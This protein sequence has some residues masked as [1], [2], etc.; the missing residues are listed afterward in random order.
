MSQILKPYTII[1]VDLYVERNADRQ[2]KEIIQDMGR[3]GY[4]LVSR[5][6]GKTNLLLNAKRELSNEDDRF[7]YVDL[8]NTFD[9]ER[10]CFQNIIDVAVDTNEDVFACLRDKILKERE[11]YLSN[12]PH[13]E[14]INELRLLLNNINGK[15]VIILDE[16]DALTKT[17]YSDRIFAQIRSMYFS[18][19]NF[20]EF[21]RLTYILSGVVEPSEI[22]KDPKISPFNI[23]EK[24]FLNDFNQNEF[25]EFIVKAR[26]NKLNVELIDRVFYWTNGNPRLTWDVCAN[27]EK[28]KD[29][30][31]SITD[32]DDIVNNLYLISY[33]KPPIDNI[34]DIVLS[35]KSIR[36][37]IVEIDY[38]K[39]SEV[40]DNIKNKLY[41]AG[42]INYEDKNIRIKNRI[43]KSAL[44]KKW[45]DSI[46][47]QED[48]LFALL[49]QYFNKRDFKKS[50]EI[51]TKFIVGNETIDKEAEKLTNY[52]LGL[53]YLYTY[54]YED[55]LRYLDKVS[56]SLKSEPKDYYI[57]NESIGLCYLNLN[58]FDECEKHLKLVID[59]CPKDNQYLS[60]L[61]N[62]GIAYS[63][64]IDFRDKSIQIFEK[65]VS[66]TEFEDITELELDVFKTKAYN[67]LGQIFELIDKNKAVSYY[68]MAL[69]TNKIDLKPYIYLKIIQVTED[70]TKAKVI[71]SELLNCI[72]SNNIKLASNRFEN[73]YY[74]NREN[75]KEILLSAFVIDES[76][77]ERLFEFSL[78]RYFT[79]ESPISILNLLTNKCL[80]QK[81]L[82]HITKFLKYTYAKYLID[83]NA[84]FV[85]N[86]SAFNLLRL[87]AY[88]VAIENINQIYQLYVKSLI[89]KA[90]KI[91]DII[92]LK[93]LLE[94]IYNSNIEGKFSISNSIT[95]FIF[96]NKNKV[97]KELLSYLFIFRYMD[98]QTKY[99]ANDFIGTSIIAN[100]IN[101]EI[102]SANFSFKPNVLINN[103]GFKQM[104]DTVKVFSSNSEENVSVKK[105]ERNERVKV[106]YLNGK[107]ITDKFKKLEKDIENNLCH[108][109]N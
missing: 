11:L 96:N 23:G 44:N 5:Q 90:D 27:I 48:D 42:I 50:I 35:D 67:N 66:K 79:N 22:I 69:K 4:V 102:S 39:G 68:N 36:D 73:G 12:S 53:S 40:A 25:Q 81:Y 9:N 97:D 84:D 94:Y 6:M 86:D 38:N 2:I 47:A 57:T 61:Y 58:Q 75:L 14:H 72:I 15:I 43:I 71:L 83:E 91:I 62:L 19:A 87:T 16:I 17:D 28:Q 89:G 30:I 92:D 95:K 93:I 85:Y 46:E 108:I 107:I 31:R 56:F 63:F 65:V 98:L 49:I 32:I 51:G 3:P 18:R 78:N 1:P 88:F 105:L 70:N 29:E 45:L 82:K 74:F 64:Q 26:L 100:I 54:K 52:Y 59:N 109:I 34:R 55:S 101:T 20:D 104:V 24:I 77:F 103:E 76:Q 80:D 33:D 21:N 10:L 99:L 13:K 37:A 106:M 7:I 60:A 41:L 8:S